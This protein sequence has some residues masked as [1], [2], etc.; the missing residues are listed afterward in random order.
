MQNEKD[1]IQTPILQGM[2]RQLH[3]TARPSV[4]PSLRL[5]P[6]LIYLASRSTKISVDLLKA[7]MKCIEVYPVWDEVLLCTELLLNSIK[8]HKSKMFLSVT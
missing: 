2:N 5:V 1:H 4:P 6:L 3:H 8:F 7:H